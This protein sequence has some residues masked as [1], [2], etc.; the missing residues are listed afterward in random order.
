LYGF[1]LF[2][3]AL[4]EDVTLPGG[5]PGGGGGGAG[6]GRPVPG[7]LSLAE[8]RAEWLAS[9]Q[10]MAAPDVR[11]GTVR[12]EPD[13]VL[14]DAP[15]EVTLDLVGSDA[16]VRVT[17][18]YAVDGGMPV[19]VEMTPSGASHLAQIPGQG[20]GATVRYY[21]R[22]EVAD[23][24]VAF[25]PAANWTAPWAYTVVGPS[26]PVGQAG[27]LVMNEVQ[28]DNATTLADPAGEFDDWVE[29]YNRGGEP[30]DLAGYYLSDDAA[31]AHQYALPAVMLAPGGYLLIWCD[32]DPDQGAD[33]APFK[34]AKEGETLYLSTATETVDT[35]TLGLQVTDYSY[36][37]AGDG[38]DAWME[39]DRPSP[40]AQNRC[41]GVPP[42]PTPTAVPVAR[43]FLP[44]TEAGRR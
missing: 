35:V 6:G 38:A 7:L 44:R 27:A 42:T 8:L 2:E 10:D 16:P 5:G 28:A 29:L 9:R 4:R 15:A 36:G 23:G 11:L 24:R 1:D 13:P 25:F 30:V 14:A 22:V 40:D 31:D 19:Q 26:L 3:R 17:L 18:V 37:R 32:S 21:V 41:S 34:I 12:V 39:C 33:H 43:L 20:V